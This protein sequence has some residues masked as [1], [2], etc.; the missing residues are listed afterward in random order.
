[1]KKHI[2]TAAVSVLLLCMLLACT[3]L[4]DD[5]TIINVAPAGGNDTLYVQ[6][7]QSADLAVEVETSGDA[8]VSYQWYEGEK[9]YYNYTRSYS[10]NYSEIE[11]AVSSSLVTNPVTTAEYYMCS[12]ADSSGSSW[13][14]YFNVC[15]DN[16]L[17]ATH[18]GEYRTYVTPGESASLEV[19]ASCSS[20]SLSYQWFQCA[21]DPDEDDVAIVGA[22]SSSYETEACTSFTQYLC[23]VK[24]EYD[25]TKYL[26][27]EVGMDNQ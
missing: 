17:S 8:V 20:G 6:L 5:G 21:D 23:I 12:I 2:L 9:T 11:G 26:N 22:V 24:D 1:M 27:F 3:A 19:Y 15:V 14:V 16:Q 25:N 10:I 13:N 7:N 4:A 18:V